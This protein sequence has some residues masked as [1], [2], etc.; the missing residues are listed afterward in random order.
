MHIKILALR[1]LIGSALGALG[2][3]GGLENPLAYALILTGYLAVGGDILISALSNILRGDLFDENFLMAIATVGALIIDEPFEAIVVMVFYQIG[4]CFQIYAVGKSR[5]SISSLVEILPEYAVVLRNGQEIKVK[6]EDVTIGEEI[7]VRPGEKIPLDGQIVKGNS[8]L[9]TKALT[10]ESLPLDVAVGDAILSGCVNV[11]GVITMKVTHSYA[12]S[13]VAKILDLVENAGVKKSKSEKFITKFAR[14]YTPIVVVAAFL[15]A[16]IPPVLGMGGWSD[17]IYRGISFLVVSCPCALVIS[18]PLGFFGGIGG[19]AKQG[20]L[21]KGGVYLES[22]AHTEVAIFDKTGTLTKG[23]FAIQGIHPQGISPEDLVEIAAIAEQYSNHPIARSIVESA[24]NPLPPLESGGE[25]A[26]FGLTVEVNGEKIHVG[27]EKLMK[28]V[29]ITLPAVNQVGTVVHVAKDS[30]YLGYILLEDQVKSDAKTCISGLKES[31]IQK[32]IMLTGDKQ[33][34]AEK[35]GRE[36]GLNLVH[37]QLLPQDKVAKLEE[38][39]EKIKNPKKHKLI[40]VGDGINDA[41]VLARADVGIAM[42]GMGSQA[43]IEAA[44]IVI[45]NDAP[46]KI[47]TAVEISKKT[48]L[49][50][51]Q[52]I[53]LCFIVKGAVLLLAT[54]GMSSLLEAILADVGVAVLAI[55]NAM[56]AMNYKDMKKNIEEEERFPE[57]L[58]ESP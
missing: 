40:Y 2:L 1:C 17:W 27:N 58:A 57:Y 52:N 36:L 39:L 7:L 48:M 16:I 56:R 3:W 44:D 30:N 49:I 26:G 14:Y 6:P 24:K 13:T 9:D 33:E 34:T 5:N 10:G 18:I 4:E 37:S 35:I 46:S 21:V 42:G 12:D 53:A 23:E 32:T 11:S 19:A 28:M 43:A 55:L 8:A 31:G 51:K 20:I 29:G 50:V 25:K 54:G 15:L 41:P 22:L 45:M 38:E 47:V